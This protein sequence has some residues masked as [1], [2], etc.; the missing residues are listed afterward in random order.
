MDVGAGLKQLVDLLSGKGLNVIG[1]GEFISEHYF[2]GNSKTSK[3]NLSPVRYLM[4]D[5]STKYQRSFEKS[6]YTFFL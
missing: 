2:L 4:L 5:F 1:A 3:P 6:A